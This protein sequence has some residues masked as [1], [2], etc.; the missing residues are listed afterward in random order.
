MTA[1]LTRRA[2]PAVLAALAAAAI[3]FALAAGSSRAEPQH[4]HHRAA[5]MQTAKARA[6][7][8]AMRK[9]WEDH[10]TWTRL[11]IV[12]LAHDLPDLPQTQARLLRNQTDIGNAVKPYYGR[13]A[14]AQLTALL[15]EHIQGAVALLVAAKSGDSA[16]IAAARTAWYDNG[17]RIAA[18][19]S[20][21][22]PRFWALGEM[23]AMMRKHLDDTLDEAVARLQGRYDDDIQAYERIHRHILRM[24]DMLSAGIV[25]QFPQRFRA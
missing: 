16:R 13:K 25:K 12:S 7:H 5:P 21:A 22:N 2:I 8:E 1:K 19:L 6:L 18:F 14:G 4:R 9:L 11:A 3:A 10:I 17:N 23:R 20:H 24:A 15:E